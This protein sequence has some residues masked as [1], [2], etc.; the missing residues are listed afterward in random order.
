MQLFE[1]N[2]EKNICH[3]AREAY[4]NVFNAWF[5][6]FL[7]RECIIGPVECII[8]QSALWPIM[9]SLNKRNIFHR[10]LIYVT[11]QRKRGNASTRA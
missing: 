9:H 3:N 5:K 8:V 11:D 1:K 10:A 7:F 2:D 6:I 4:V